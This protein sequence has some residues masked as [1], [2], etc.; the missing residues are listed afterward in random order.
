MR[1]AG[2]NPGMLKNIKQ[3]GWKSKTHN[4]FRGMTEMTVARLDGGVAY[5][6]NTDWI[7]VFTIEGVE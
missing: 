3:V 7:P 1:E 4:I 5:T 2:L 6:Q